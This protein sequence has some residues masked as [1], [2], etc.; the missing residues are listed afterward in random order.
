M[1]TR[2]QLEELERRGVQPCRVR[3]KIDSYNL[4]NIVAAQ[5]MLGREVAQFCQEH[6][7]L[8]EFVG[9][10]PYSGVTL[11]RL[12]P[13]AI[14]DKITGLEG[15]LR[16]NTC[17]DG[18]KHISYGQI[19]SMLGDSYDDCIYHMTIWLL[20]NGYELKECDF[21]YKVGEVV[22]VQDFDENRFNECAAGIHF[23][24]DR[25]AAEEHS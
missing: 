21:K 6:R 14:H 25:R 12:L 17:S 3:V 10:I 16:Y 7:W 9:E 20:D 22:E 2:E 15:A 1:L 23:Y 11:C 5:M 24:V 13:T 4:N 18:R 8:E 19:I